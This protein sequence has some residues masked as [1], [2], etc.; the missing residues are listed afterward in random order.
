MKENSSEKSTSW[1]DRPVFH[2]IN[3]TW[4]G[5]IFG[6]ILLLAL[7]SRFYGLGDRVMSH[8]ENSH[9]YYSWRLFKGMGYSHTP[10]THG[11]LQFHLLAFAYFLLGDSDFSA[12][13][14]AAIFSIATIGFLWKY[15]RY[16]GKYGTLASAGMMLISPYMLFYGR[17]AR[18][19]AFS[20]LFGVIVIWS[21]LRYLETHAPRYLYWLT[22]AT[23]LHFTAKETAFIYTAQAMLFLGFYFVFKITKEKWHNDSYRN[24]F[25]IALV[26]TALFLGVAF[27]GQPSASTEALAEGESVEASGIPSLLTIA[28]IIISALAFLAALL[29]VIYGYTWEKLKKLP[30]FSALLL[31]GTLVLP[32]LA[33]FPAK[34]LGWDPIDY[35]QAGMLRTGIMVGILAALAIAIGLLWNPKEWLINAAIFYIP[36]TVFYT[37]V[38]TNGPGFFTGMVGSLGYWIAQQGV[39]RGSQPWYYYWF[40]QIP[41]YEYLPALIGT[42]TAI[43]IGANRLKKTLANGGKTSEFS[44]NSEVLPLQQAPVAALLLFW[45][46]TSLIAYPIAG[47]KMPWLTVHITFPMILLSGLGIEQLISHLK[48]SRYEEKNY[49][50]AALLSFMFLIGLAK[51][52]GALLGTTP[53]FQGKELAQLQTTGMFFTTLLIT[54]GS[55][56]GLGYFAKEISW[57]KI[58]AITSLTGI[59]ILATLTTHAAIQAAYINYDDPT[60]Y[61]VYAHSARGV[62]EALAQI[63]EL[64]LRTTDGLDLQIAY[65]NSGSALATSSKTPP[66]AKLSSIFGSTATTQ[67]TP[68]SKIKTCRCP[69]GVPP[70]TCASTFAK[71]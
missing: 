52:I 53:P 54:I 30:S 58:A 7:I 3:L 16:L 5:V 32:Q 51:V 27:F 43:G 13:M 23:V 10:V 63:E 44:E 66:C 20:A 49:G 50:V 55:G 22:A 33:P 37:T 11:P 15:R 45:T 29:I 36:F 39:E 21:I 47:E 41:I 62:K 18:N 28:S 61:L 17:Y 67:N 38:F 1:L 31:L 34:I 57:R 35:S 46:I 40:I 24:L 25:L 70:S 6:A 68:K 60:E 69:T 14:P 42:F 48:S 12:R 4:E 64:S 2:D 56:V 59:A 8:D 65:D 71:T 9:V 26:I 19:E